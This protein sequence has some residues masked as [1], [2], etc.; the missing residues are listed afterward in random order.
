MHLRLVVVETDEHGLN[1]GGRSR[2]CH[3]FR[4]S[5]SPPATRAHTYLMRFVHRLQCISH[6]GVTGATAWC[7]AEH[8]DHRLRVEAQ[9]LQITR[10]V[11]VRFV[12]ATV[13]RKPRI[14]QLRNN[15]PTCR[16]LLAIKNPLWLVSVFDGTLTSSLE[17][18]LG[19][20]EDRIGEAAHPGPDLEI[21]LLIVDNR[22]GL[23]CRPPRRPR[24]SG[25]PEGEVDADIACCEGSMHVSTTFEP[26]HRLCAK[27]PLSA[28]RNS[29]SFGTM[30]L[31]CAVSGPQC[32]FESTWLRWTT[33]G[34]SR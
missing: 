22:R 24:K 2:H 18:K 33:S 4:S 6:G 14:A 9:A 26:K 19:L 13:R 3:C 31:L 10:A 1:L 27:R 34:P 20:R 15:R 17:K 21:F 25:W 12:R 32:N 8:W 11:P 30:S 5:N 7:H 16:E 29:C 23:A 28:T